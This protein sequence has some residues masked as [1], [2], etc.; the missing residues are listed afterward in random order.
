MNVSAQNVARIVAG[1]IIVSQL[2]VAYLLS[3]QD[4]VFSPAWRVIL[5]AA[6]VGLTGLALYLNVRMPGQTA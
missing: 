1:V 3:Q 5:G 4:V 2:M 6:N